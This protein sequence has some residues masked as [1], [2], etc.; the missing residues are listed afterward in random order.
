[1]VV[2]GEQYSRRWG[3]MILPGVQQWQAHCISAGTL[4]QY[5]EVIA[6]CVAGPYI[7]T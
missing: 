6:R 2:S 1:M 4:Q 3:N 7:S 5:V